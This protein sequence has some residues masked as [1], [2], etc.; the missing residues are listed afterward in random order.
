MSSGFVCWKQGVGDPR[1]I[2][3]NLAE[4]D[5]S[6]MTASD[7]VPRFREKFSGEPIR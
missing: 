3:D 2:C 5:T 6:G 4:A 1:E 7:D